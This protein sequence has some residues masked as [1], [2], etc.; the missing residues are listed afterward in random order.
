[1]YNALKDS[2]NT[3]QS[4]DYYIKAAVT[5]SIA[6]YKSKNDSEAWSLHPT[7]N[8]FLKSVR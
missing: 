8:A 2:K 6:E 5:N 3:P 4:C 1:M 7:N